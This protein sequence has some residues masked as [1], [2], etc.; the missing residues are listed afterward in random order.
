MRSWYRNLDFPTLLIWLSLCVCGLVAIYSSTHGEAQEFLLNTVQNS[1]QRQ[2]IWLGISACAL[3]VILMIP[4]HW[5][6]RLAPLAYLA[7][8]GL[9]IIALIAGR[10][11]GGAR[12][13]VYL[14]PFGFQSSELAKVGS[15]LM[16]A[17]VLTSRMKANNTSNS[18][19]IVSGILGLPALLII[20]QNDLGTALV[21]AGFIPILWLCSGVPLRIV[22]LIII[23][24]VIGYIAILSWQLALGFTAV[25]GLTAWF[26]TR[27]LKWATA[28]ALVGAIT[29]GTASFAL[30]S[31]L[32]PHHVARIVSF[33]NPEADEY[34]AGVGFHL[35]QSKAA[36]GSGGWLG[37]G[38]QS[39]DFV[40]SVIGEEWGFVGGGLIL[41]LFTI[42]MLRLTWLAKRIDHPFGSLLAA[43]AAGIFLIHVCVNLG[44]VLGLLPVIGIPLPFLSYGGSALLTNT[45]LL[46]LALGA[47]MRRADFV[48][49]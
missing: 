18:A 13:W 42:L 22:G 25:A 9:L 1:F 21:F 39:T 7:T 16:S 4:M 26:A 34:R 6:I 3:V 33:S 17:F 15:L 45:V 35:V 46:S 10:E 19:L 23:F 37:R 49:Y 41:L 48:L 44:M 12:S 47:Y 27:E 40:F 43:G 14:G 29:V 38:E 28:A 8:I 20:L 32:Q 11:V 30:Q 31:V 2:L 36:L 5:F 24:P